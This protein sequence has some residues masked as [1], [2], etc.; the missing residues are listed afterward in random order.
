[1][2][3]QRRFGV[4]T[5]DSVHEY[6]S[7][8][9]QQAQAG[10]NTVVLPDDFQFFRLPKDRNF[11]KVDIL[12]FVAATANGPQPLARYN[13]FIHRNVGPGFASVV[14]PQQQKGLPCPICEYTR[15]LDWHNAEDMEVRKKFR[16]Q[17]RQ[18]YALLWVDGPE[19]VR[20]KIQIFDTSEYG[21]GRLLDEKIKNRDLS[22]PQESGWS[23]YADLMEGWTLKLNLSEQT[24][25]GATFAMVSSIDFKPRTRQYSEEYYDKVPDLS[26]CV[27]MMD[28]DAIKEKFN[29]GAATAE[30]AP[31]APTQVKVE[32]A[33]K[34]YDLTAGYNPL[35]STPATP[36]LAVAPIAGGLVTENAVMAEDDDP[37]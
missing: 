35:V 29:G 27:V 28:Y 11:V 1:M 9:R 37:F 14:C 5:F 21:F 31:V 19:D 12:P 16:P 32:Q 3:D 10:S 24:F 34:E 13:Y 17:Q 22:D 8:Q 7:K 20:N 33:V 30:S 23:Q 26:Q 25:Q 36:P 6:E 18:L 15:G 4:V 2:S